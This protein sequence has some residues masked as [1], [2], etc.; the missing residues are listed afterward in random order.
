MAILRLSAGESG[1]IRPGDAVFDTREQEPGY[2]LHV[3]IYVGEE[4]T[5]DANIPIPVQGVPRRPSKG[6]LKIA[7]WNTGNTFLV[8]HYFADEIGQRRDVDPVSVRAVR[9]LALSLE[10][11]VS[12][13]STPVIKWEEE[14]RLDLTRT[15]RGDIPL[16]LSGTC[17]QWVAY[18][19][20]A[21]GLDLVDEEVSAAPENQNQPRERWRLHPTTQIHAFWTGQ[22]PLRVTWD[23]RLKEWDACLFG[24][25]S[26]ER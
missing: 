25:R 22:Y 14:R 15:V 18:V 6:S 24:V 12:Q 17:S 2:P 20:R 8:G 19:Y 7:D 10:L 5:F 1:T 21:A 9:M 16:F 26:E 23:D 4:R 11:E 3:G 13:L